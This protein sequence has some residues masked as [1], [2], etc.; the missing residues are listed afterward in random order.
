MNGKSVDVRNSPSCSRLIV[1]PNL[2]PPR[3][4]ADAEN[5]MGRGGEAKS[6]FH[7]WRDS[8]RSVLLSLNSQHFL[9][10][11]FVVGT[12]ATWIVAWV[13]PAQRIEFAAALTILQTATVV[14]CLRVAR[15]AR[16]RLSRVAQALDGSTDAVLISRL[17]GEEL[18]RNRAD[19]EIFGEAAL[20]SVLHD[21]LIRAGLADEIVA[22]VERGQSWCG[23][24]E[25][26]SGSGLIGVALRADPVRDDSGRVDAMIAIQTD[27][28]ER[29]RADR[30]LRQFAALVEHSSDFVALTT[31][32]GEMMYLNRAGRRLVGLDLDGGSPSGHLTQYMS[33]QA[34]Q[35]FREEVVRDVFREGSW[36]G[37][38]QLV[39]FRRAETVDVH[40]TFFVLKNP[41]TAEPQCLATVQRDIRGEQ[42]AKQSILER[43]HE[44]ER[45]HACI[46]AQA[47]ELREA[48]NRLEESDR[49]RG[50][51]LVSLS[52]EIRTPL[53]AVLGFSDLLIEELSSQRSSGHVVGAL[54]TIQRNGQHL[55]ALINDILDL[56]KVEAGKMTVD[57]G[58]CDMSEFLE[59][60]DA[61][62]RNRIEQKGLDFQLSVVRKLPE[63]IWTDAMRLRQILINLLGNALKFTEQGEIRLDVDRRL[64]SN[65]SE[66][67]CFRVAD[68]G[69]GI[70]PSTMKKLFE[71]F[72]Q[73]ETASRRYG[74]TGLG[75][76]ISL[77]LANLLGGDITAQSQVGIGTEFTLTIAMCTNASTK[78]GMDEGSTSSL[79]EEDLPC[80][81][82]PL[83]LPIRV[84]LAEDG[85]DNQ[86][87]IR[88]VLTRAGA[89]VDIADNGEV[90][91]QKYL[92]SLAEGVPYDL[93]LMDMQMPVLD[94]CGATQSLRRLGCSLPIVALTANAS[95]ECREEALR[96]GCTDF[97]TKPIVQPAL[98]QTIAKHTLWNTSSVSENRVPV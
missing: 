68:T 78:A 40:A 6:R 42:R 60:V 3:V 70:D 54:R 92:D 22:R 20:S 48:V 2:T 72:I 31:M 66:L 4:D 51:F 85:K 87:L 82:G 88:F 43:T 97:A 19:R 83:E 96:A 79:G 39:D 53:T 86:R 55:L 71:P 34:A 14:E 12:V 32:A 10:L 29:K 1:E 91:V 61:L 63:V 64:S 35:S 11:L 45:A 47:Q 65:G 56:S 33:V 21:R 52:H 23:D 84:L 50:A 38:S 94:G 69:I 9:L 59:E 62:F 13:S 76:S 37:Q 77:R 44:L 36:Q 67:L 75:L 80:E 5:L 95:S 57:L 90:C 30:E 89:E 25:M 46:Q 24:V 27:T 58:P 41:E 17:N 28:S 98:L 7:L 8:T 26:R 73:S 18:Y 81:V 93:V 74:G 49:A 16:V 15:Q